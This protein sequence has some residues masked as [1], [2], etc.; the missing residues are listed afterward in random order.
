MIDHPE[1]TERLIAKLNDALP[2]PARL[3]PELQG[4]AATPELWAGGPGSGHNHM[5]QLRGR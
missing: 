3:T 2:V 5:D 1:I 4:R